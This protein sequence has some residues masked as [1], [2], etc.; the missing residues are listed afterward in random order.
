LAH[1][2]LAETTAGIEV[3]PACGIEDCFIF[4]IFEVIFE[5]LCS[6]GVEESNVID[7][8]QFF[9]VIEGDPFVGGLN[10]EGFAIVA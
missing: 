10:F 2:I 7:I 8:K 6:I 9:D 5:V 1:L 3:F 4:D